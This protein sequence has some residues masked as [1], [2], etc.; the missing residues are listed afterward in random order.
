ME[1]LFTV[2]EMVIGLVKDYKISISEKSVKDSSII[3]QITECI[4]LGTVKPRTNNFGKV[5]LINGVY[6]FIE[7]ELVTD[8]QVV[9]TLN[10]EHNFF[11]VLVA[12]M[13]EEEKVKKYRNVKYVNACIKNSLAKA[14]KS[15]QEID[16]L[17]ASDI[18]FTYACLTGEQMSDTQFQFI[19]NLSMAQGY[20]IINT[21]R[22]LSRKANPDVKYDSNGYCVIA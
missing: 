6:T 19:E 8:G 20:A 1:M 14:K 15:N 12:L 5:E 11:D 3:S 7:L 10:K 18:S 2:E 22:Y 9:T 16:P 17:L 4:N 13:V 21:L